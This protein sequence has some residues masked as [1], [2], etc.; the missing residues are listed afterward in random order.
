MDSG[1]SKYELDVD[2]I[3][4]EDGDL[5]CDMRALSR[6]LDNRGELLLADADFIAN[7]RADVPALL[8]E[9]ER[10]REENAWLRESLLKQMEHYEA[11]L[12]VAGAHR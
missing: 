9:V 5:V 8:A 1:H 11:R 2:V 10:L 4:E 6:T 3:T 12:I 7:A